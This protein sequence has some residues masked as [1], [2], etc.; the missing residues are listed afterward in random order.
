MKDGGFFVFALVN[1]NRRTATQFFRKHK[2]KSLC[3]WP[4]ANTQTLFTVKRFVAVRQ[5]SNLC[6]FM[7][8]KKFQA[9][10]VTHGSPITFFAGAAHFVLKKV[11]AVHWQ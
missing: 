10:Y 2:G 5:N 7:P 6:T 3:V 1:P 8:N 11:I 9:E 4:S